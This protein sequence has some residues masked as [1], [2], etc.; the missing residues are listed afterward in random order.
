MRRAWVARR[1]RRGAW[2][3]TALIAV[4]CLLAVS[5]TLTAQQRSPIRFRGDRTRVELADGRERTILEGNARVESTDFVI[6]ADRIEL[7]GDNFR[8]VETSGGVTVTDRARDL[9]ITA[10]GLRFDR[11]TE[12]VRASGNVQVEDRTNDLLLKG[13]FLETVNG[14]DVLLV[15]ISVRVLRDD[16]TARAQFLRYRRSDDV[17]ELSGFPVVFRE[18]D[19]YRADRIVFNLETDE[20]ELQG[21]VEGEIGVEGEPPVGE[22]RP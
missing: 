20:I 21:G 15:Q 22:E 14:G 7:T 9:T 12:N 5:S 4:G 13:G 3:H 19:E 10:A 8:F 18:G 6:E 11:D 16:L 1:H 17:L 2:L